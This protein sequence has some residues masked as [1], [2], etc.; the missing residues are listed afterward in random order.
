M[1]IFCW[2]ATRDFRPHPI[3]SLKN[4]VIMVNYAK[5]ILLWHSK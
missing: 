3:H 1:T 5:F 4:I 2:Q